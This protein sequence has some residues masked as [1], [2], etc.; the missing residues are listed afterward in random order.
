MTD[1]SRS[2]VIAATAATFAAA[3]TLALAPAAGAA[4]PSYPDRGY[5]VMMDWGDRHDH[6]GIGIAIM[7]LLALLLVAAVV[8]LLTWRPGRGHVAAGPGAPGRETPLDILQRRFA[9]G[10][11]DADEYER[12]KGVLG[13]P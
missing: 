12:R 1:V 13:G 11:I 5:G 7:V 9:A 8:A 10:E 6:T 3:V 2:T 4:D